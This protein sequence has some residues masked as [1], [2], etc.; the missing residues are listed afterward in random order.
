MILIAINDT[1]QCIAKGLNVSEPMP[2]P[3]ASLQP[4]SSE[5]LFGIPAISS[6]PTL[7]VVGV[8]LLQY[9][10]SWTKVESAGFPLPLPLDSCCSLSLVTQHHAEHFA[11]SRA[12]LVN[13]KHSL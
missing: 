5:Q 1:M 3:A 8:D 2:S 4:S 9:N 6:I 12:D 13:T 11:K 10:I 7:N